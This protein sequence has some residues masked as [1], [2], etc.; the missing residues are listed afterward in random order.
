ML[1]ISIGTLVGLGL[2]AAGIRA[3]NPSFLHAHNSQVLESGLVP[4]MPIT[5]PAGRVC[6]DA[7]GKTL[8]Y[9]PSETD[10]SVPSST[11]VASSAPVAT[12][13][14]PASESAPTSATTIH[15]P[16]PAPVLEIPEGLHAGLADATEA[17]REYLACIAVHESTSRPDGY[18]AAGP[19]Y[20]K[21]QF[22]QST[23]DG[24]VVSINHPELVGVDIR[25]VPEPVQDFV[26][27]QFL[28]AGRRGEWG[29]NK[30]CAQHLG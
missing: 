27:L 2:V 22:L 23:W 4:G 10:T 26:A 1:K 12:S 9:C 15:H 7:V 5:V 20:G 16:E 11:V 24:F 6:M 30:S 25:E 29:P 14:P 17:E 18:N 3:D 8:T 19:Y 21:Y 28:R 13:L